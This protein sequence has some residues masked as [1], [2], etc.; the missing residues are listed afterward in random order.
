MERNVLKTET[1]RLRRLQAKPMVKGKGNVDALCDK[2]VICEDSCWELWSVFASL[3]NLYSI[4]VQ[5]LFYSH[6]I[7]F[8][9]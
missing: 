3:H 7:S 2:V 5:M 8:G 6:V 4:Q 9:Q 1:V